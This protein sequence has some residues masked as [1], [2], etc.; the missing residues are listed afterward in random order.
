MTSRPR[1]PSD[2]SDAQWALIE[3]E[4]AAWRAARLAGSVSGAAPVVHDL[5]EI[6]NA[7]LYLTR[8]GCAW[9]YLPHD[10]P[11]YKTVYDY[12]AKWR[13]DATIEAVHD[14][15]R[16][17]LRRHRG[18]NDEPSA[19]IIDSQSVK[20]SNAT[21]AD[22]VGYDAGKKI[23]GRKRHI[24]VDTLG[25]LVALGLSAASVQ[26]SPAGKQVLDHVAAVAPTV[27]LA[28][29]DGGH[30]QSVV[31]H[32]AT[33]GIHVDVVRRNPGDKGFQVLPRRWIVE[34]TF[35]WLML[36]R[37]LARD[38]ETHWRTSRAMIL[39]AMIGVISRAMTG[40]AT[41]SWRDQAST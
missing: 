29:V 8:T 7:I 17:E 5:R 26:D 23:K 39:M 12:F 15:L 13:D 2:L 31:E 16:R 21:P 25:L 41:P 9:A 1:Y 33:V 28:W 35:G 6:M 11:P 38:Y 19:V 24:A 4:L 40:H 36:Q 10:F 18:R 14:I 34:R 27:S 20:S 22:T 32:G 30:N 37:R 3:P